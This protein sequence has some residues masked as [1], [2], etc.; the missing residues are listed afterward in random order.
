M[1]SN[2]SVAHVSF[3]QKLQEGLTLL[4]MRWSIGSDI[5]GMKY[6]LRNLDDY[7]S[8]YER[9]TSRGFT[10]ARV[11][12]IGFGAQPIRLISLMSMGVDARGIDLD[13][14][15]LTF[16]PRR[17]LQIAK[18]NGPERALKTAMRNLL[19]DRR[20]RERLN[21]AL[22]QRGCTLKIDQSRFLGGDAATFEYGPDLVDLVYSNDVVEHIPREGLEQLMA[23]LSRL[24]SPGGLALIT[25]SPN[26]MATLF[27]RTF[28]ENPSR[29]NICVSEDS[30]PTLISIA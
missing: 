12:E 10:T 3:T 16:S 21:K 11:L 23:R 13:M 20:D 6:L 26:G 19:F 1:P 29:G 5:E 25:P 18:K 30:T 7:R 22:G 15:M 9:L 14:P 28:P 4:K 2:S 8:T 27:R 17:V 24:I